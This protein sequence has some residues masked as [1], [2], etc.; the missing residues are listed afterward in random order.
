MALVTSLIV[1]LLLTSVKAVIHLV[2]YSHKPIFMQAMAAGNE[3]PFSHIC[4]HMALY[5][6]LFSVSD[7]LFLSFT[8]GE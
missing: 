6:V 2:A 3:N 8:Q 1:I 4:C 5:S 7:L